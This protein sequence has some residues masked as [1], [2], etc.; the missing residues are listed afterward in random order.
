LVVEYAE[1]WGVL[2]VSECATDRQEA[3]AEARGT[4]VERPYGLRHAHSPEGA[5][6]ACGPR[7]QHPVARGWEPLAAWRRYARQAAL[8]AVL[9]NGDPEAPV[10]L[11]GRGGSTREL[12]RRELRCLAPIHGDAGYFEPYRDAVGR[13]DRRAVVSIVVDRWLGLGDVRPRFEFRDRPEIGFGGDGLFG[14]LAFQLVQ[15][16]SRVEGTAICSSCGKVYIPFR[17]PSTGR[18]NYCDD[19]RKKAPSRDYKRRVRATGEGDR[20]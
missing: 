3:Y 14:A 19:C 5:P 11:R 20:A 13:L 10:R 4:P 1:Q 16:V 12:R 7:S 17:R 8:I 9:A 2:F 18:S 6:E 15:I